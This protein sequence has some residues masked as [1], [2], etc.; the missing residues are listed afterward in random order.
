MSWIFFK[1]FWVKYKEGEDTNETQWALSCGV[2][3]ICNIPQNLMCYKRSCQPVALL[4]GSGS[5]FQLENL[6]SLP[7]VSLHV[8]TGHWLPPN[9]SAL[10]PSGGRNLFEPVPPAMTSCPSP[11]SWT[12]KLCPKPTFPPSKLLPLCILSQQQKVDHHYWGREMSV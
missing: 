5:G 6:R 8:V 3:W 12:L 4:G 9:L 1:I 10:Q 11:I 2:I 7:A